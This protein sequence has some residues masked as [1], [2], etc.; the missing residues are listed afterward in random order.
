MGALI[1]IKQYR[2]NLIAN[3][4]DLQYLTQCSGIINN[5]QEKP[6]MIL[7]FLCSLVQNYYILMPFLEFCRWLR[8]IM[9]DSEGNHT[10][11]LVRR[12]SFT[13]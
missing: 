2:C 10:I 5:E 11:D 8:G 6:I 13:H 3:G 4:T 7:L 12:I 1:S 9:A